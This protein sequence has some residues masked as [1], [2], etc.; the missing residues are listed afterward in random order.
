MK[1]LWESTLPPADQLSQPCKA[2]LDQDGLPSSSTSTG[3]G[4]AGAKDSGCTDSVPEDGHTQ[5]LKEL[6]GSIES[7][8][9]G[10]TP[11]TDAISNIL[12]ILGE[13]SDVSLTRTQKEATFDSYLTEIL[14]IQST[15]NEPAG[16]AV[17]A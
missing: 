3:R 7:F 5:V 15:F 9:K 4:I 14:S 13:N 16:G 1:N 2:F 12:C 8:R 17:G 11:K 10:K 6:E